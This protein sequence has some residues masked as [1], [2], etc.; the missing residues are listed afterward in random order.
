MVNQLRDLARKFLKGTLICLIGVMMFAPQLVL[1]SCPS[2]VDGQQPYP[3][4]IAY[5]FDR[6]SR[7]QLGDDGPTY[8]QIHTGYPD[9]TFSQSYVVPAI[10]LK[11]IAQ[12][13]SQGWYHFEASY[14]Q[15]GP[16]M[17][18]SRGGE[19]ARLVGSFPLPDGKF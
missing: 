17:N 19:R 13:E 12:T 9:P 5:Q 18:V 11:A 4:T 15:V 6:A 1:A 2:P 7:N 8:P 14:G 10:I 16:T 3:S